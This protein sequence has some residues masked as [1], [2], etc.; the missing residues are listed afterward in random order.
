MK[1]LLSILFFLALAGYSRAENFDNTK[2]VEKV[3][4][5]GENVHSSGILE[6]GVFDEQDSNDFTGP[7]LFSEGTGTNVQTFKREVSKIYVFLPCIFI[8]ALQYS[9]IDLPPPSFS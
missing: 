7:D 4:I 8:T 3:W 6:S 5:F 9:L 2:K 1:V